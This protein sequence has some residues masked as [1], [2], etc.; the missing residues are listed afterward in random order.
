[1]TKKRKKILHLMCEKQKKRFKTLILLLCDFPKRMCGPALVVQQI[2]LFSLQ[3]NTLQFCCY[4]VNILNIVFC[5]VKQCS[6]RTRICIYRL[7]ADYRCELSTL[8]IL[9]KFSV[10]S[11]NTFK[12]TR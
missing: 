4:Q 1:M 5:K 3:M 7:M 8:F 11:L 6:I 10:N 2:L 12:R 9:E